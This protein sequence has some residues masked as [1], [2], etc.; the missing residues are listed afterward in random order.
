MIRNK[1]IANNAEIA[2]H[3]IAGGGGFPLKYE[4]KTV[5]V[6]ADNG[7]DAYNGLAVDSAFKTI[8]SAVTAAG[9]FSRVYVFPKAMAVGDTDPNSYAETVIVPATHE[10]LQIIGVPYG[11]RTQGGMPQIKKGSGSTAQLTIRAPGCMIANLGING[12]DATGGGI[13]LDDDGSTK[14]AFG[15]SI[16][17]CHFKNCVGSTA[18]NAATGGAIMWA[19]TGGGWQVLI[20]GNRFY[21]NVGDIVMKGTSAAIPQDV[22]IEDNIF[23]GPAASVDC[24]IYVAADGINGVII[25]NNIFTCNP[26]IASGTNASFLKLTG[27]VGILSNNVFAAQTAEGVTPEIKFGAEQENVV[28]TTVFMAGNYGEVPT[29]VGSGLVSGEIFRT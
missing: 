14:V 9:A 7:N 20:K 2:L 8:Q 27:C 5:Y 29:G 25:N 17:G 28:P 6:D 21:K 23:S 3:K 15:T 22:V 11:G 16:V 12:V 4:G 19:A 10:C 1:A 24:N 13:L 18:T 26:D